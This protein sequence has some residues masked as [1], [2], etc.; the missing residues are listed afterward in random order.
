MGM[1]VC[2]IEDRVFRLDKVVLVL[3]SGYTVALVG[4][5]GL[6]LVQDQDPMSND[7]LVYHILGKASRPD[8]SVEVSHVDHIV[9]QPKVGVE[10]C[11][12]ERMHLRN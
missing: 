10:H 5:L 12:C 7:M 11:N 2:H 1:L 9:V 6:G 3:R 8:T 4:G